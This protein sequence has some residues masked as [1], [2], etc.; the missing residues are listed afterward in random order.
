MLHWKSHLHLQY[1]TPSG[2]PAVAAAAR[3]HCCCFLSSCQNYVSWPVATKL[4]TM[5]TPLL[6]SCVAIHIWSHPN[7]PIFLTLHPLPPPLAHYPSYA[8]K[9]NS[10]EFTFKSPF[11]ILTLRDVTYGCLC[12]L[13][14]GRN[15]MVRMDRLV[16]SSVLDSQRDLKKLHK[17]EVLQ[18]RV[19]M[20]T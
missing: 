13:I 4:A 9:I 19:W 11:F 20:H 12:C 14:A 1:F 3:R 2:A 10:N 5:C 7:F 15:F 17:F 8:F 18:M 6:R 16:S